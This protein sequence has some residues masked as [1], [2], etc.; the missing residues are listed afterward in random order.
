MS[1]V[2]QGH[3]HLYLESESVEISGTHNEGEDLESLALTG[4]IEDVRD[5]N[6]E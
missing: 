4:Y 1:D 6:S 5:R 3:T 2:A